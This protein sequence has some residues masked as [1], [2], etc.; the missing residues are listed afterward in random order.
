[1]TYYKPCMRLNK[2]NLCW[3]LSEGRKGHEV[4]SLTLA[5]GLANHSHV[6]QFILQQP[7]ET[8]TPRII[9]G[10]QYGLKWPDHEPDFDHPPDIIITAG[11]KAAAVG[12]FISQKFKKETIELKHIQILDPKD[13]HTNY[14]LLLIPSHDQKSGLN[15]IN[16]TGSLHPFSTQ[17]FEHTKPDTLQASDSLAVILGNPP[18]Q[19]YKSG[20]KIELQKIRT[21]YP[22]QALYLCGSPRLSKFAINKIKTALKTNDIFWHNANNGPNPYQALLQHAKH[23]FVTAD[24]IN[25]MNECA[26]TDIPVTLLAKQ[27][28]KSKKHH[29]FIQSLTQRWQDFNAHND[30]NISPVPYAMGEVLTKSRFQKLL[31]SPSSSK[32]G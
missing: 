4:Q 25:M 24:S 3:V 10:F 20:F 32:G 2:V 26:S 23:L 29:R 5:Q 17:W 22:N 7:W 8:F 27:Y 18:A 12:K 13:N 15:I 11:K 28:I 30:E 16:F 19:Y 21:T 9:P 31:N 6:H 14:D 1:M